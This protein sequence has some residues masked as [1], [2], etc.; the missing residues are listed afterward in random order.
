MYFHPFLPPGTLIVIHWPIRDGNDK[1]FLFLCVSGISLRTPPH[2]GGLL[3][4]PSGLRAGLLAKKMYFWEYLHSI[5][6]KSR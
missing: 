6:G 4:L 2:Q 5:Q 1:V 3:R